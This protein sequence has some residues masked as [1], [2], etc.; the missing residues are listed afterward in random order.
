MCVHVG[1]R[2]KKRANNIEIACL[3]RQHE[4]GTALPVGREDIRQSVEER[5]DD[6]EVVCVVLLA[7]KCTLLKQ[8]LVSFI[9]SETEYLDVDVRKV[10]CVFVLSFEYS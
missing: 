3:N 6:L 10:G 7:R 9:N 2:G 5:A 8:P 1:A 4:R